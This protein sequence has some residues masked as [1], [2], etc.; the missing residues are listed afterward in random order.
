MGIAEMDQRVTKPRD[1]VVDERLL[2]LEEKF[3]EKLTP[4]IAILHKLILEEVDKR[5]LVSESQV[6]RPVKDAIRAQ[7][8][9]SRLPK[10]SLQSCLAISAGLS[11]QGSKCLLSASEMWLSSSASAPRM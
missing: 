4:V 1:E 11:V 3:T 8:A 10:K 6:S 2:T 5:S 9:Y 7:S